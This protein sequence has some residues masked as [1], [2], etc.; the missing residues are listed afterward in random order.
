MKLLGAGWGWEAVWQEP[1]NCCFSLVPSSQVGVRNP[2]P[3]LVNVRRELGPWWLVYNVSPNPYPA[4]LPCKAVSTGRDFRPSKQSTP[5]RNLGC[6]WASPPLCWL[7]FPS[8]PH[9]P[10]LNPESR[11]LGPLVL[12]RAREGV[13]PQAQLSCRPPSVQHL[14]SGDR[15]GNFA[16]TRQVLPQPTKENV[17]RDS[18]GLLVTNYLSEQQGD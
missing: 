15:V 13:I 4:V 1:L 6:R 9:L 2:P 12:L 8:A 16:P 17:P 5:E 18:V 11:S 3:R 7:P 10:L 14:Q